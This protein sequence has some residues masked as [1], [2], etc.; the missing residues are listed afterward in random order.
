VFEDLDDGIIGLGGGV[1]RG[2][3]SVSVDLGGAESSG[4]LPS[5]AEARRVLAEMLEER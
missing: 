3:G 5:A 1:A 2:Y 4:G